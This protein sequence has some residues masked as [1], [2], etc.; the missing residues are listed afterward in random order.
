MTGVLLSIFGFIVMIG[1]LIFIHEL[2]HFLFAKLFGVY[3]EV[4]SIGFVGSIVSFR[5][6]ETEYRLGWLPL[7]GFV[8]MLGEGGEEVPPELLKRAFASKPLWQRASVVLAGPLANILVLPIMALMTIY[9]FQKHELSTTVGTVIPDRPAKRAGILPGDTILSVN[10]VKTRYFRDLL[11]TVGGAAER[12]I[13]MKIRRQDKVL[14]LKLKPET[15]VH[16]DFLGN[17]QK[18]GIIGIIAAHRRPEIGISSTKSPA[19]KAGLR[20]W[21]VITAID[22]VVVKRWSD[23]PRLLAKVPGKTRVLT[24]QR[25]LIYRGK[26]MGHEV[27]LP[28]RQAKVIP[29]KTK[30]GFDYGFNSSEL[31]VRNARPGTPLWRAGLRAGDKLISVAGKKLRMSSDLSSVPRSKSK[32]YPIVFERNGVLLRKTFVLKP[33]IWTDQFNKKHER[34]ML[35]AQLSAPYE[36]GALVPVVDSF[37]YALRRAVKETLELN[38]LIIMAIGK[39]FTK[40]IP[41][42]SIGGPIMIFQI[43]KRAVKSGWEVFLRHMTLISINLGL[44]NLLPIPVLDG[45]HLMFFLIEGVTRKPIPAR[46]RYYALLAGFVF[47]LLVMFLAFRNDIRSLLF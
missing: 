5:W 13:T 24:Y 36:R 3:V 38:G 17:R 19:Y 16:Y 29:I 23:V 20:T 47:L 6:G 7:G 25:A 27:R 35:G 2:G 45:G 34:I 1:L 37:G 44:I 42:E 9:L 26:A 10:G 12:T 4:F 43:A 11:S 18:R 14:T 41:T 22:G 46:I 21:D 30:S 39:L 8:K 28:P 31:F 33:V 40:E 32:A 15:H